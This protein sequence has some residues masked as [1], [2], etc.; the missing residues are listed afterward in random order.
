MK[1]DTYVFGCRSGIQKAIRRGHLDLAKVSFDAL[2]KDKKQR[3][4]LKWRVRTLVAEEAWQMMGELAELLS[5][6]GVGEPEWRQFLYSLTLS[7]KSKDGAGLWHMADLVANG[8]RQDLQILEEVKVAA[9]WLHRAGDDPKSVADEIL[10]E[11]LAYREMSPYEQAAMVEYNKRLKMGGMVG[12]Q[13]CCIPCM[14]LVAV[15]GIDLDTVK[16][17]V[18]Q[19]MKRWKGLCGDRKPQDVLLPWYIFDFHTRHGKMALRVFMKQK[20][21]DFGFEKVADFKKF[22][23][24][25]ESGFVPAGLKNQVKIEDVPNATC[26]H[27]LW[28]DEWISHALEDMGMSYEQAWKRWRESGVREELKSIIKWAVEKT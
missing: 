6:K 27:A 24:F 14:V 3:S 8:K 25:M 28:Y 11:L 18:A 10:E 20:A 19:G 23:F 17:G 16:K 4:W 1:M 21:E 13:Y 5:T 2:W 22:W 26:I 15:R 7:V 9:K 12:D